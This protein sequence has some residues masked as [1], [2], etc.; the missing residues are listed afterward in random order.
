MPHVDLVPRTRYLTLVGVGQGRNRQK[1]SLT[2]SELALFGEPL[3]AYLATHS[4]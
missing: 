4:Q 1:E 2:P 3:A